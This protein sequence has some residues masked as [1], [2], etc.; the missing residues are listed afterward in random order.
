M[1]HHPQ[2]AASAL[3]A[4]GLIAGIAALLGWAAGSPFETWRALTS[5]VDASTPTAGV[6]QLLGGSAALAAWIGL[7]W[8]GVTVFLEVASTLPGAAGRG[9]TAIAATT[10]PMLVRRIAQAMIGV[11]VL[12]GPM[13]AGSAF[14]TG[15][16]TT[17]ST[18]TQVD[19]PASAATPMP[20]GTTA[21]PDTSS[22]PDTSP[23]P[24]SLDR[25]A[26]AFVALSPPAAQRTST[27]AAALVTGG[28][29]RDAGLRG[30]LRPDGYVVHRGDTLWDIAARHLGPT[31]SAVDIS[32]AW[33]AWYD[34]NRTA[35]GPD[36]GVIRPGEVLMP[37]GTLA[38][39]TSTAPT[40]TTPVGTR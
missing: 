31:A 6:D 33:P 4:G 32:R 5:V 12:A 10:S 20:S 21:T 34:A 11:S 1:D 3:R 37:P 7:G 22:T 13:T 39:P 15:P 23:A 8:L 2:R 40:S 24:L 27:G 29:H 25:P 28:A 35:I 17:T 36:P 9:C 26:T 18:S 19:R 14:A 30:G 38:A 16:S